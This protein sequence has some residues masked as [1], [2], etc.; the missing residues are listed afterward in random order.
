MLKTN[1]A[2]DIPGFAKRQRLGVLGRA[3]ICYTARTRE[4]NSKPSHAVAT[5]ANS[6]SK[7]I[8]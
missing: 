3:S 8:L 4:G 2:K 6:L 7:D 5:V 1:T